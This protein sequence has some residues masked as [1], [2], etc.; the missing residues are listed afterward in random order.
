[1]NIVQFFILFLS[2]ISIWFISRKENW[3]KW[4]FV[5]GFISQPFWLYCSYKT[6]S[7]GI[8]ILSFFYI[9]SYCQGIYFTFNIN[10]LNK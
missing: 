3:R 1:M 5:I 10:N 4:G 6:Q 8:F 9:Y 7:W 2:S